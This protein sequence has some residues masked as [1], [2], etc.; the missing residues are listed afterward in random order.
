M[1]SYADS[2][3][4]VA[5]QKIEDMKNRNLFLIISL[6]AA[7]MAAEIVLI[8]EFLIVFSGDELSI[9]IILAGWLISIAAGSLI[10]GRFSDRIKAKNF[11]LW[12]CQI[13]LGVLLPLEIFIIR[14][15]R[16]ILNISAGEIMPFHILSISSFISL[17][18]LC[19]VMGFMFSLICSFSGK[20][21]IPAAAGIGRIYAMEC[22]GSMLGGAVVSLALIGM[23]NS[24]EI[25]SILSLINALSA[26]LFAVTLTGKKKPAAIAVTLFMIVLLIVSWS[27]GIWRK[28]DISTLKKQWRGYDILSARN[29]IYG[30]I[31]A[32]RRAGQHSIF[33]NGVRLYTVP[34]KISSEEAAHFCLLEHA[35]PK[36]I[37]LIGGGVG[38]L[39]DEVLKHNVKSVDYLELDPAII[40][41]AKDVFPKEY[42]GSLNDSRVKT[43]NTDGRYFIKTA[44]EKYDCII[45]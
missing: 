20:D 25:L 31:A 6:G 10:P 41:T 33:N 35:G 45:N 3:R 4:H 38:G 40:K 5:I 8:R 39:L 32:L 36:D 27:G 2:I 14:S 42:T 26:L 24:F 16:P 43:R 18:P 1:L 30:N 13:F 21:N 44:R 37:L 15:I 7:A 23:M 29:S 34:D 12:S 28:S 19:A 22:L 9:G 11:V 17:L